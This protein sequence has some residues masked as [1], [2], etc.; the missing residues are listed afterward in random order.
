MLRVSPK[1]P[2]LSCLAIRVELDHGRQPHRVRP[3]HQHVLGEPGGVV[4]QVERDADVQ[5]QR[6]T[7]P[8][9]QVPGQIEAPRVVRGHLDQAVEI[10]GPAGVEQRERRRRSRPAAAGQHGVAA[11]VA[12]G[13]EVRRIGHLAATAAAAVGPV[14]PGEAAAHRPG[15][16][17][18][19]AERQRGARVVRRLAGIGQPGAAAGADPRR[20]DVVGHLDDAAVGQP[21]GAGARHEVGPRR[22][23]SDAAEGCRGERVRVVEH[24]RDAAAGQRAVRVGG[25]AGV[26]RHQVAQAAPGELEADR[27]LRP[28]HVLDAGQ[29]LVGPRRREARIDG[30]ERQRQAAARIEV[31]AEPRRRRAVRQQHARQP[32]AG[33]RRAEVVIRVHRRRVADGGEAGAQL[34][35]VACVAGAQQ[36]LA[37]VGTQGI[38]QP[39]ARRQVRPAQAARPAGN[40]VARQQAR[41]NRIGRHRGR[42]VVAALHVVAEAGAGGQLVEL[43]DVLGIAAG[44]GVA[45]G[46][47]GLAVGREQVGARHA[48]GARDDQAVAPARRRVGVGAAVGGADAEL[49]GHGAELDEGR[50]VE[51]GL[52]LRP[53]G[54]D[55]EIGVV[56][57]PI[58]VEIG[59][60]PGAACGG[61]VEAAADRRKQ[62]G[63]EERRRE[64]LRVLG[65]RHGG[66]G[67][68][69]LLVPGRRLGAL[70]ARVAARDR[71]PVLH[72]EECQGIR[73]AELG[74]ALGVPDR[75]PRLA[76]AA[77]ERHRPRLP[78]VV[79]A[80]DP[81]M[82]RDDRAACIGAAI[83]H[84]RA[85]VERRRRRFA[86][87]ELAPRWA[88][89]R[90]GPARGVEEVAIAAPVVVSALGDQVDERAAGRV[91]DVA[92]AGR[93]L[94]LADGL[95][96]E[97]GGRGAGNRHVGEDHA[98]HRPHR[99]GA[100]R[101]RTGED[102]LDAAAAAGGVGGAGAAGE[103]AGNGGGD[104]P[105]IARRQ[106]VA[107]LIA[108]RGAA[109]ELARVEEQ[110]GKERREEVVDEVGP[111]GDLEVGDAAGGDRHLRAFGRVEAD[112][113][114]PERHGRRR[115]SGKTELALAVRHLHRPGVAGAQGH[116]DA[117]K[118]LLLLVGHLAV[119]VAGLRLPGL[120][121]AAGAN[122][123]QPRCD[124]RD[125]R[126][127]HP[128][129]AHR[130]SIR[131]PKR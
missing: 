45:D 103:H 124:R 121:G 43:D 20:Q 23:P 120:G 68:A 77:A 48:A 97:V 113:L 79:G 107:Q 54:A 87:G 32:G 9:R 57:D 13:Q 21:H 109:G 71:R 44:V 83:A 41:K 17:Q 112:Q 60:R 125:R 37:I 91:G 72:R 76:G 16:E 98:V 116:L 106:D 105:G 63:E 129:P 53:P 81:G 67:A 100:R 78:V 126:R 111:H 31:A 33:L 51:F 66:T 14:G 90:R 104:R 34:V 38:G 26:G 74:V 46:I 49:V 122:R 28:Q 114:G 11:A 95:D 64:H 3:A 22:R 15:L 82:L 12:A 40:L 88:R 62:P 128:A 58:A 123:Q 2:K 52:A 30:V 7:L 42:Q 102:R 19:L 39:G 70:R 117:G 27:H 18:P 93:D 101:A 73:D 127:A 35:G 96:V 1:S 84:R 56:P 75:Q 85:A 89:A 29:Q 69:A 110:G 80:P 36:H 130:N 108:Q 10:A 59:Q 8:C 94:D 65:P 55:G 4:G 25:G 115:Q 119:D 118:R 47:A 99:V 50:A 6:V 5:R 92:A 131:T 24:Q 61:Q 86:G